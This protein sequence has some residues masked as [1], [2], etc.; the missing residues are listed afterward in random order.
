MSKNV[1]LYSM[2]GLALLVGISFFLVVTSVPSQTFAYNSLSS[3]LAQSIVPPV[4]G[5]YLR[6]NATYNTGSRACLNVI[7][8]EYVMSNLINVS[9]TLVGELEYDYWFLLNISDRTIGSAPRTGACH[10]L[11]V[12]E[13]ENI[14]IG[15]TIEVCIFDWLGDTQGE[16]IGE[17]TFTRMENIYECWRVTANIM[18][19]NCDLYYEKL[20]GILMFTNVT[21]S[22][23]I[24]GTLDLLEG[25]LGDCNIIPEFS[26]FL[27]LPLF[28]IATLLAVIA[29]KRKYSIASKCKKLIR[30]SVKA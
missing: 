23:S 16:V 11:F 9:L 29:Y 13:T 6:Y 1:R 21:W 2:R 8:I 27:I 3:S 14:S 12:I 17:K 26:S 15:T 30:I 4:P 22:G 24:V 18:G 28:M 5:D 19:Y 10:F 20:S 25:K 7:F